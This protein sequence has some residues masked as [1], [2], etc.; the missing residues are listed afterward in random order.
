MLPRTL[1]GEHE[2]A[3]VTSTSPWQLAD[4]DELVYRAV[5]RHPGRT[6]D[7]L[8]GLIGRTYR[9]VTLAVRRLIRLRLVDA[10][11]P[12]LTGR[13]PDEAFAAVLADA[14]R[15]LSA[16]EER[17]AALRRALPSFLADYG[18]GETSARADADAPLEVVAGSEAVDAVLAD[19]SGHPD[20]D[21]LSLVRPPMASPS[22]MG[23]HRASGYVQPDYAGAPRSRTVFRADFFEHREWWQAVRAMAADGA[24][25]RVA[26]DV[27][28]KLVVVT[29]YAAMLPLDFD[30]QDGNNGLFV[31][32]PALV[33]ALAELFDLVWDRAVPLSVIDT[34]ADAA[35]GGQDLLNLLAAGAKDETIARQLD[36]S[37]RTVR[38]HVAA[39]LAALG[40]RTR[41]Q[42]GAEAV[43][44]GWL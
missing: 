16:R 38:R 14:R 36:V 8:A 39:L 3:G 20:G 40:A 5:L 9:E 21:L 27:P 12:L 25:I 43:R 1:L 7:E 19:L 23:H 17:L 28:S 13:P 4:I 26:T 32:E 31:R 24:A 37:L 11:G 42:A 18:A 35:R 33:N 15:E 29:G 6:R 30:T 10:T 34:P 22:A 44:R 41:F 2:E